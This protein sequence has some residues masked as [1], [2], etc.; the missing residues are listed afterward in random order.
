MNSNVIDSIDKIIV[1]GYDKGDNPDI[2]L[3][4]IV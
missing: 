1:L 3:S 2:P 4:R